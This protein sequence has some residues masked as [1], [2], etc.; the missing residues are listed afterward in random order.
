MFTERGDGT[1]VNV[2]VFSL[3]LSDATEKQQV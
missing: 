3:G 1:C 2:N